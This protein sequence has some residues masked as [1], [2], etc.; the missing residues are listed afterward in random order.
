M[1]EAFILGL[2]SGAVCLASCGIVLFPYM[3]SRQGTVGMS[4][5]IL[6]I[7]LSARLLTYLSIGVFAAAIGQS[8]IL[9][10]YTGKSIITGGG[11][12]IFSAIL[13]YNQ[14]YK[15][16]QA[17]KISTGQKIIKRF[18]LRRETIPFLWGIISS[19]NLCPPLLLAITQSASAQMGIMRTLLY[20][21]LFFLGTSVYF[22]PLPFLGF[23]KKN[24]LY[25]NTGRLAAILIGLWFLIKGL[26]II[27]HLLTN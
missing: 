7:Y 14:L 12:M 26:L 3:L 25:K 23:L 4:I 10:N 18:H 13:L 1:N 5:Q 19:I 21:S 24:E 9:F 20:F 11:F 16:K 8:F 17:C 6:A 27:I 15:K 22:V 2:S